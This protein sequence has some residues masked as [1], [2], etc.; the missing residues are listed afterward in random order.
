MT[1][2]LSVWSVREVT[3]E[4]VP[5]NGRPAIGRVVSRLSPTPMELPSKKAKERTDVA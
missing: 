3:F 1:V 5:E 2:S 4:V